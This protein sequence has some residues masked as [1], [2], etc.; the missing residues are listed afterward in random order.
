MATVSVVGGSPIL[1]LTDQGRELGIP[2]SLLS[3]KDGAIDTSRVDPAIAP[4]VS[5]IAGA[6]LSSGLLAA[7][8]APA[9]V[10]ALSLSAAIAGGSGNGIAVTFA[11]V[12]ADAA[13]PGKST[14][15]VNVTASDM[16]AGLTPAS[17]GDQFG[18]PT[19]GTDPGLV[20]L[21]SAATKLPAAIPPTKLAVVT[22]G[23]PPEFTVQAGDGSGEA[24]TLKA[25][26]TDA[27]FEDVSVSITDVDTG[28]STF[29]LTITL[30][31]TAAGVLVEDLETAIGAVVTVTPGPD[32][33][34][35]PAAG[36]WALAGGSSAHTEPAQPA[37]IGV[38]S[39]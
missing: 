28:A 31:H 13:D 1:I 11:N 10:L 38:L 17:L 27:I 25:A 33:Y 36:T 6:L 22:A 2:L 19:D 3:I 21:A 12:V 9:P 37:A 26:G 30:D 8:T 34:E 35:V 4:T 7:G 15:D 5:K 23:D 18:T 29:T 20:V 32:G 24:F 39:D 14:V 16:R